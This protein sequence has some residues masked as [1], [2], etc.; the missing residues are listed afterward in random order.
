MDERN[1]PG[2]VMIFGYYKTC[3]FM[4]DGDSIRLNFAASSQNPPAIF[5]LVGGP[6][7]MDV[8][9]RKRQLDTYAEAQSPPAKTARNG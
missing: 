4:N 1:D 5:S 9:N 2:S 3:Q 8:D 6:T 7:P